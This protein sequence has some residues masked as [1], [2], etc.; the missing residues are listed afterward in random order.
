MIH[1]HFGYFQVPLEYVELP[2]ETLEN[3]PYL[4]AASFVEIVLEVVV[5]SSQDAYHHCMDPS[6]ELDLEEV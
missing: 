5:A 3:I 1:Q 2:L 6:E 4:D